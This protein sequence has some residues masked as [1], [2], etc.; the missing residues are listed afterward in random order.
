MTALAAV[1]ART[2]EPAPGDR[3]ERQRRE[4][5]NSTTPIE[6]EVTTVPSLDASGTASSPIVSA[7]TMSGIATSMNR[8]LRMLRA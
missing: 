2:R 3:N 6:I 1:E 8:S 7:K 5:G 4:R